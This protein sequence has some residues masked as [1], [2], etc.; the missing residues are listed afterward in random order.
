[1]GIDYSTLRDWRDK[2]PAISQALKKGK[3]VS[4]YEVENALFTSA[5]GHKEI[6]R[7]PIKL[8]TTK[9]DGNKLIEEERVEF[10]EEQIYIPPNVAA[11]IFWLKNRMP[12]KW[13]DKPVAEADNSNESAAFDKLLSVIGG[14][15][16]D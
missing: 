11:Q 7:K 3:E 10:V 14:S 13:K 4:N 2:F 16:A 6:V 9:R 8:K 5:L 15:N 12:A 1:M